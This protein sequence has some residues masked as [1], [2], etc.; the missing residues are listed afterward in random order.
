[1][2]ILNIAFDFNFHS[3]PTGERASSLTELAESEKGFCGFD[4][5]YSYHS[6][7]PASLPT[8]KKYGVKKHVF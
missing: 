2:S 6:P 8:V 7:C 3:S 1:V 4:F 5:P